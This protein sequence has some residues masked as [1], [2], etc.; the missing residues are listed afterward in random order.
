MLYRALADATVLLHGAF[1]LFVTLGALLALRWP[2][3]AW[4]HLPCLAWGILIELMRWV[5]PLTPLEVRLREAAGT[6]GYS[7]GF[8]E[9]YLLPVIYPSDLT[10]WAQWVFALFLGVVNLILYGLV[11]WRRRHPGETSSRRRRMT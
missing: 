4:L 2:R 6:A 1:I 10:P 8:I 11:L 9:H 3:I 5:C 7:G